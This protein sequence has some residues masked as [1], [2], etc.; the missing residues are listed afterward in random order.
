MSKTFELQSA[1]TRKA[2]PCVTITTFVVGDTGDYD[3]DI[4]NV[5]SDE[6]AKEVI[7]QAIARGFVEEGRLE[8][9]ASETLGE[10]YTDLEETLEFLRDEL[11]E[12]LGDN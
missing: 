6:M 9:H 12:L 8:T 1:V 5:A 3:A 4:V 7:A 2:R 10:P 11:L